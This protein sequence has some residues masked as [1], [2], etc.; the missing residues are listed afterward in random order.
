MSLLASYH[1]DAGIIPASFILNTLS[2]FA[3]STTVSRTGSRSFRITGNAIDISWFALLLLPVAQSEFYFQGAFY[4]PYVPSSGSKILS[5]LASD[6]TVLG[7][8]SLNA[9]PKIDF[10]TGDFAVKVGTSNTT[11]ATSTWFVLEL[12]INISDSGTID[13][14]VNALP[15][16]TIP[17]DTKPGTQTTISQLR[18]ANICYSSA[19]AYIYWDD[20]VIND[21]TGIINNSW[22]NCARVYYLPLTGDGATKQW[23]VYPAGLTH[24][25][26]IDDIPPSP[27]D[28]LR[29]TTTDLVDVFSCTDLPAT[30]GSIKAVIPEVYA[31]KASV[32]TPSSLGIGIDIGEGV[33]FS[34]DILLSVIQ[35]NHSKIWEQKPGGGNFSTVDV[36]ALQLYLKSRP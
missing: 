29:A 7:G 22:P 36:N 30:A 21:T 9:S 6:G 8:I 12:H 35:D 10:Y 4:I 5:W 31:F 11:F 16:I 26:A 28:Y 34:D 13:C 17:C 33:E 32:E 23:D 3:I 19:A 2:P 18:F 27:T 15:D 14:C 25:T 24:Y 1:F 20:I